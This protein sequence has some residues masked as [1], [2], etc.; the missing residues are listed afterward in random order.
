MTDTGK[1]SVTQ[2][3]AQNTANLLLTMKEVDPKVVTNMVK[4]I[5]PLNDTNYI[6]WCKCITQILK[7]C[8][9]HPYVEGFLSCPDEVTH[10][11][12]HDIWMHNNDLV[13]CSVFLAIKQDQTIHVNN[14]PLAHE[15]WLAL[16]NEH[17][18]KGHETIVAIL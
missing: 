10:K 9:L 8:Q 4:A 2:S 17:L 18:S 7:F 6:S 11:E 14:I 16:E 3:T 13:S 15:M 5:E 1:S 12:A